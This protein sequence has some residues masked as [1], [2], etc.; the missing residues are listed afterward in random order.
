MIPVLDA[1]DREDIEAVQNLIISEV[2]VKE[3]ELLDDASGILVKN[4][5]PNFKVLGPRFGKD[6][7]LIANE[8]QQ[9]NQAQIQELEREGK[10]SV[11]IQE[12]L[13]DLTLEEVEISSQDIEGW[14]VANQGSLT[15]ALDVTISESLKDEGIA[16]ELINRIQNLRKD[17]GLE[18]TD[19][20][21]LSIETNE[22]LAKAVAN[23]QDYIMSET[24]TAQLNFVSEIPSGIE[25]EFDD[26][27][28]KMFIQKN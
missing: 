20:I 26:V 16:R 27:K 19:K 6:M 5:K 28:S 9:F 14:L 23:N 1:K 24:L 17:S 2:N 15:V 8:V 7:K 22:I 10:I 13:V 4:I 25:I 18:V 21:I 3:I 12:N 11:T